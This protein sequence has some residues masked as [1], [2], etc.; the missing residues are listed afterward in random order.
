MRQQEILTVFVDSADS[1]TIKVY[2]ELEEWFNKGM[3]VDRITQSG[4]PGTGKICIT[5]IMRY[6]NSSTSVDKS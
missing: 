2:P 1:D 3:Y 4:V 6:Y 5:F